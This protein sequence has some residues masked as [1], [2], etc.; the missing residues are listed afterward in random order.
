MQV[1]FSA[2]A[3]GFPFVEDFWQYLVFLVSLAGTIYGFRKNIKYLAWI[4]VF[5]ALLAAGFAAKKHGLFSLPSNHSGATE[6]FARE[7]TGQIKLELRGQGLT[8]EHIHVAVPTQRLIEKNFR[9][10]CREPLQ[11]PDGGYVLESPLDS[12]VGICKGMVF[13]VTNSGR[14]LGQGVVTSVKETSCIV[15][16]T[17]NKGS[18]DTTAMPIGRELHLTPIQ[19]PH[20]DPNRHVPLIRLLVWLTRD[21]P[22]I[23]GE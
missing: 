23:L 12:A 21:F 15:R 10:T 20:I 5:A 11:A 7:V 2:V 18:F 9:L 8:N 17:E 1:L 22:G 19:G 4:S 6:S 14:P 16:L 3:V 13:E